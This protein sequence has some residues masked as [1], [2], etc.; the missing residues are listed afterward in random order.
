MIN[1]YGMDAGIRI[2]MSTFEPSIFDL[3]E[4][5]FFGIYA[6]LIGQKK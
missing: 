3:Q 4:V 2:G 5:E 1:I 6:T